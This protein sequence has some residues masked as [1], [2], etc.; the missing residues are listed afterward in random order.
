M[1]TCCSTATADDA[2]TR[3]RPEPE[4][5]EIGR[6]SADGLRSV[7]V[8]ASSY[9]VCTY[10]GVEFCPCDNESCVKNCAILSLGS[11]TPDGQLKQLVSEVK[12]NGYA[13]VLNPKLPGGETLI[14]IARQKVDDPSNHGLNEAEILS[15][16]IYTG[17]KIQGT[18]RKHMIGAS[19]KALAWPYLCALLYIAIRKQGM[20][21][22]DEDLNV[23]HGLHNVTLAPIA[24]KFDE[25]SQELVISS[26][27]FISAS[28]DKEVAAKFASGEGGTT[29]GAP[30]SHGLLLKMRL[31][32]QRHPACADVA[33]LSKFPDEK[34]VLISPWQRHEVTWK[35]AKPADLA[36]SYGGTRAPV[37]DR[38]ASHNLRATMA[39]V[40]ATLANLEHVESTNG[41]T[42]CKLQIC[43]LQLSAPRG[44]CQSTR[45]SVEYLITGSNIMGVGTLLNDGSSQ[46]VLRSLVEVEAETVAAETAAAE[47]AAAETAAAE[48]AAAETA[49]EETAAEEMAAAEIAAA[50]IAAAEC[51]IEIIPSD[52]QMVPVIDD[53][54]VEVT[55]EAE[56][57]PPSASPLHTTLP[58]PLTRPL[59]Y[60][61]KAQA[62]AVAQHTAL[63]AALG[64]CELGGW[65]DLALVSS[66]LFGQPGLETLRNCV[67]RFGPFV[68]A[69]EFANVHASWHFDEPSIVVDGERYPSVEHYF[70]VMKSTSNAG[71]AAA[72]TAILAVRDPAEA[73]QMA[74]RYPLNTDWDDTKA[75]IMEKGVHAKF[76]QHAAL[77][78]LLLGTGDTPLVHVTKDRFWGSGLCGN[79]RNMLGA[80]L[81]KVR[82]QLA[83][84]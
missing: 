4:P 78:T 20:P 69:T 53:A 15:I 82:A 8:V 3:A 50:E 72:R 63:A 2:P 74:R 33:W 24:D 6:W 77:R 76:S 66:A 26:S 49:A 75:A 44:A 65:V 10:A 19:K 84:L 71:H 14:D 59:F 55:V 57:G 22:A 67:A 25:G 34:E 70:Q 45:R 47:T 73:W 42:A 43:E 1:G 68:F 80:I 52:L 48:T 17:T 12:K 64:E 28:R 5:K 46:R 21:D 79:G 40:K 83:A 11:M 51:A 7:I 31:T 29:R 16:L 58:Q 56:Q 18:F 38:K 39:D 30:K 32:K 61:S 9:E 37:P 13:A 35:T 36:G 54:E 81:A 41:T 23:Y 60:L 62:G 27:T